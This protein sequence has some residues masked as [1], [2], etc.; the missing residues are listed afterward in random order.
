MYHDRLL[1]L[2]SKEELKYIFQFFD[3]VDI[4]GFFS[5]SFG[6]IELNEEGQKY[7]ENILSHIMIEIKKQSIC[8]E[9]LVK[10]KLAE[11][12]IY[13][14]RCRNGEHGNVEPITVYSDKYKKI[15]EIAEYITINYQKDISLANI[16]D[17][18]YIS[19]YYLS[20]IYKEITWFTFNE[21]INI[22]RIKKSQELLENS[23][24]SI[25]KIA[26]LV[27]YD[28]ITYF[29]KVFKKYMEVSPLKY[30]KRYTIPNKRSKK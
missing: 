24:H 12:L 18:F 2:I 5:K 1:I 20:K 3:Q 14:V 22:I 23:E 9:A 28:S 15:N 6:I 7:V 19:K 8:Y 10:S 11:L 16:S 25:T 21:Y 27:G 13:A 26:E 17:D 29:E 4:E 30:R